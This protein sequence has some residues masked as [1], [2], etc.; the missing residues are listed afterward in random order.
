MGLDEQSRNLFMDTGSMSVRF[1]SPMSSDRAAQIADFVSRHGTSV[2]DLGCGQGALAIEI[3]RRHPE[4]TV[5]GIDT[6]AVAIERGQVAAEKLLVS[7]RVRLQVG[8]V[9]ESAPTGDVAL[10]VGASHALGGTSDMFRRLRELGVSTAVAGD[11]V[12]ASPPDQQH[13][14]FFGD[15]PVG[16]DGLSHM[17]VAAGWKVAGSYRSSLAEWDAFEGGWIEGVRRIG[18][19]EAFAFAAERQE[20]YETYRGVAGFGWVFLTS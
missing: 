16:E 6:D 9:S 3:A 15:L 2:V 14:D 12:W 19:Q 8:D 4:V 5:V 13:S 11:L 7:D 18:S 17:A 10:C 1:N 20:M